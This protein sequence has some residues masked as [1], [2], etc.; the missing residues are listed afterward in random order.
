MTFFPRVLIPCHFLWRSVLDVVPGSHPA[1]KRPRRNWE[2]RD[3]RPHFSPHQRINMFGS[4]RVLALAVAL[5]LPA[6]A[7]A[8][9]DEIPLKDLKNDNDHITITVEEGKVAKDEVEFVLR[10][11]PRITWHK[12]LKAFSGT[13]FLAEIE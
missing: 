1:G 5:T 11:A 10:I 3:R 4:S 13:G 7:K 9:P 12:K 2:F 6:V 8:G